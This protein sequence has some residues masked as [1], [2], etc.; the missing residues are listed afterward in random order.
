M[1]DRNFH[2]ST[3]FQADSTVLLPLFPST[4]ENLS[5]EGPAQLLQL[6]PNELRHDPEIQRHEAARV[7]VCAGIVHHHLSKLD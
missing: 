4:L 1:N 3:A 2:K 5:I 7:K 6:C